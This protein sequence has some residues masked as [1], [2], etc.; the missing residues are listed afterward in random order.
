VSDWC[1]VHNNPINHID[2]LGLAGAESSLRDVFGDQTV[3]LVKKTFDFF[4]SDDRGRAIKDTVVPALAQ[5]A[6][7]AERT[8]RLGSNFGNEKGEQAFNAIVGQAKDTAANLTYAASNPEALKNA[9]WK[10]NES[11]AYNLTAASVFAVQM[12]LPLPGGKTGAIDDLGDASRLI[13]KSEFRGGIYGKLKAGADIERHHMP[14]ASISPL[15][16]A[17]GP[18]IQMNAMDHWATSSWGPGQ[19]ADAYRANLQLMID[20]GRWRDAMATEI[21]DVRRAAKE[22]SNDATKYNQ[23]VR[24]MLD[25]PSTRELLDKK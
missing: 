15:T 23:P 5:T 20:Q 22:V 3:V 9:L 8:Y 24:E 7:T 25:N 6:V 11:A 14:A 12:M 2:P 21:R 4:R 13:N 17:R 18:A 1:Y 19:A 16:R 10:S